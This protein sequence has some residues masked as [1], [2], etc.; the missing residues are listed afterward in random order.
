MND[1][2]QEPEDDSL[3]E[4]SKDDECCDDCGCYHGHHTWCD[5]SDN[6]DDF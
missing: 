4:Y 3:E 5:Q 6:I 2:E 1:L